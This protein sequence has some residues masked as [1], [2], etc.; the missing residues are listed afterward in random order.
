MKNPMKK[1]TLIFLTTLLISCGNTEI[2][3]PEN[4]LKYEILENEV[5]D[6][7]IKTQ[8]LTHVLLTEKK[9]LTENK[10]KELLNYLFQVNINKTG[11]EYHKNPNTVAVYLYASKE[12]ADAGM[13]QWV[14][15]ISKMYSEKEPNFSL[16]KTQFNSLKEKKE[17]KWNLTYETRKKIWNRI[18]Y[19]ERNAQ[20]EADKK[21]PTNVA[22]I[23]KNELIKN[24]TLMQKNKEKME[25]KILKDFNI[26]AETLEK[27]GL[28]GLE[29]GWSFP[30]NK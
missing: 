29:N 28:E 3:K 10:L 12:K 9:D 26:N 13:G 6:T 15:M 1:I 17:K 11:F 4:L 24:A 8:I 21:I 18:I 5:S 7:P 25:N 23:T 19:A 30:K 27:V 20:I 22:G 2:K 16:S 14:A